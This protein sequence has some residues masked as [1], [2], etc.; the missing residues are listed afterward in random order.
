MISMQ[1][2][3]P[4]IPR[5]WGSKGKGRGP[6]TVLIQRTS[7]APCLIC[8]S[9][10]MKRILSSCCRMKGPGICS[11]LWSWLWHHLFSIFNGLEDQSKRW[12]GKDLLGLSWCGI[13]GWISKEKCPWHQA[14]YDSFQKQREKH[15]SIV[16]KDF[17][18]C[19]KWYSK[20][21]P[22]CPLGGQLNTWWSKEQSFNWCYCFFK[23]NLF[24]MK[25]LFCWSVVSSMSWE[26]L[27]CASDEFEICTIQVLQLHQFNEM[28][29][30]EFLS[31]KTES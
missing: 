5:P 18:T 6:K 11:I 25:C 17:W 28:I 14:I 22:I 24:Q 1:W 16:H 3:T 4:W 29:V 26:G 31:W 2:P 9:H 20:N 8:N 30:N 19:L 12:Q 10:L 21:N 15:W 13:C 23:H 27:Q 7:Q